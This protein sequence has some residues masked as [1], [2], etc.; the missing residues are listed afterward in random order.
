MRLR[1]L[2]KHVEEFKK[3]FNDFENR[4]SSALSQDQGLNGTSILFLTQLDQFFKELSES[5]Q[6][7]LKIKNSIQERLFS[8]PWIIDYVLEFLGYQTQR[9]KSYRDHEDMRSNR[10]NS[11]SKI[12]SEFDDINI[13]IRMLKEKIYGGPQSY[14]IQENRARATATD[15]LLQFHGPMI[16]QSYLIKPDTENHVTKIT[17]RRILKNSIRNPIQRRVDPNSSSPKS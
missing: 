3:R 13:K 17:Y 1:K 7:I 10:I 5:Q 8:K 12:K 6:A 14:F 15:Q 16:G 11:L 2:F 4:L 9:M